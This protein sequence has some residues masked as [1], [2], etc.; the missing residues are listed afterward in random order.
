MAF[1]LKGVVSSAFSKSSVSNLT[2]T[3]VDGVTAGLMGMGINWLQGKLANNGRDKDL[4]F[5]YAEENGGKIVN[6]IARKIANDV[7]LA[8]KDA[9]TYEYQQMLKTK[10]VKDMRKSNMLRQE[11]IR[12][13][14]TKDAEQYGYIDLTDAAGNKN[15]HRVVAYDDWGNVCVDSLMLAIPTKEDIEYNVNFW[16]DKDEAGYANYGSSNIR[17]RK[18]V[19]YDTTALVNV[20]SERNVLLTKVQ[21]RDYTRKELVG[22][23]DVRFSVSGHICSNMPDV[24][25]KEE[26]Q[27]F[28]QLM[29]YK[30]VVEVNNHVVNQFGIKKLVILNFNLPSREGFKSQQDYSF[31][32]VGIQPDKE[33]SV[34]QDTI[35]I[36]N[37]E[38]NREDAGSPWSKLIKRKLD[39]LKGVSSD[40]V[41]QGLA[42]GTGYL[43]SL[44]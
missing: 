43:D 27:K 16:A 23:G 25:P 14:Q 31:E 36:I 7:M 1:N 21:G 34:L 6:V 22:N 8:A 30:G 5:Y 10:A 39:N 2:W 3:V 28:I 12:Q 26:V 40:A 32:A 42:L 18:L 9:I 17:G 24:Y 15:G 35:T 29:N 44:L 11:L 13:N 19:W 33:I 41:S 4:R 38:I 37:Q 20:S